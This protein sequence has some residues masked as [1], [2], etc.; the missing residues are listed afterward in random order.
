M[1][2]FAERAQAIADS[3][4]HEIWGTDHLLLTILES[5]CNASLFLN[6][7]GLNGRKLLQD[8]ESMNRE[9]QDL[10]WEADSQFY[11][12]RW[13]LEDPVAGGGLARKQVL[14]SPAGAYKQAGEQLVK[15]LN[16]LAR[17]AN[18]LEEVVESELFQE[19]LKQDPKAGI[20]KHLDYD[21]RYTALARRLRALLA[22]P[23]NRAPQ[24][25]R[26][27]EDVLFR[28]RDFPT[29]KR[30]VSRTLRGIMTGNRGSSLSLLRNLL[31]QNEGNAFKAIQEQRIDPV[32]LCKGL[33]DIKVPYRDAN[34]VS[35]LLDEAEEIARE[36]SG[37]DEPRIT[38][39]HLLI[40]MVEY[41]GDLDI[42]HFFKKL[43]VCP[44][45]LREFAEKSERE[46]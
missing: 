20:W 42:T 33:Q 4:G 39:L 43:G 28:W 34:V 5:E 31:S 6:R 15:L 3:L 46:P 2:L 19:I 32:A 18:F 25:E 36:M 22:K 37:V 40:T 30:H 12:G 17:G 11:R 13:K 38:S 14:T 16:L 27:V 41:R 44:V 10:E 7:V 29:R 21:K 9:A 45:K 35:D 26:V 24:V 8:L 1:D 23:E